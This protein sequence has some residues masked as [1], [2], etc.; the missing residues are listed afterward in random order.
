MKFRSIKTIEHILKEYGS[1]PGAPT[2]N[3]GG[4]V[5]RSAKS[6]T[7]NPPKSSPVTTGVKPTTPKQEFVP[8]KAGE[9]GQGEVYYNDRGDELGIVKTPIGDGPKP[10]AVVVQNPKNKKYSVVDA[11][12]ELNVANPEYAEESSSKINKLL[13]KKD[14]KNRLHKKIKKLIRKNKLIEQGSEQL[15]EINF[16]KKSIAKEALDMPINCGFEAE[17]SWEGISGGDDENWLDDYSWYDIEEMLDDQEGRSASREIEQAYEDWVSDQAMER[18]GDFVN[19][20]VN[21]R[22]EDEY[23][24]NE[25]IENEISE[26]DIEDYKERILDDLPEEDQ[27]EYEDWDFMNWGRQYVEEELMDDFIEY[28]EEE[29]RDSGEAMDRAYDDVRDDYD[30]DRWANYEYG[31]WN[32]CLSEYGH[33]LS[34]PDGGGGLGTV[35]DYME[36]WAN[37]NSKFDQ[38]K[39]GDYHSYYGSGQSYWRVESDSSIDSY[40]TGAEIISP[41]YSSPREMLTEMKKLFTWFENENVETNNSTGLHVTMSFAG[42]NQDGYG[43]NLTVNKVK[44]ALLLGDKYLLSTFGRKGN[45]YAKSQMVGLEKL[46]YKLKSDPNNI[47]TIKNIEHILMQGISPDKFSSINFKDQRD[48]NTKNQLI[49]FR[50]GG[51][52]D[53]HRDFSTIT[54]AVVRYATTLYAGHDDDAYQGDYVKA[55]FRL[56]NSV[57][58]ISADDEERVKGKIE[59]P[60]LNMLKDFFSKNNYVKY[61]HRLTSAFEDLKNYKEAS[62][63]SADKKWKQ[64]IADYEKDTGD[65]VEIEEV[66][67]GE[68]LRGYIRP[69]ATAPSRRAPYYLNKA[70]EAFVLSVAQAGY[71]LSQNLNRAPVNAKLIGTMRS[72]LKEFELNYSKFDKILRGVID[73]I[74]IS[75]E[76]HMEIKPKQRLQRVKN[77]VDRLFKKDIVKEPE[78]ISNAQVERVIQGMWH[79]VNS[80]EIKD[81]QQS[82]QFIKLGAQAMSGTNTESKEDRLAA[83]L[84]ELRTYGREYKEFHKHALAGSYNQ[85]AIFVPGTAVDKKALN[86]FID[87]LK[88]YPEWNH[89]VAKG[90]STA[91]TND[92]SYRENAMSKLLQKMRMRWEHIED[93]REE[94]PGL[95]ID[96]IREISDLVEY[97]LD[98]NKCDEDDKLEDI[99]PGE[100]IENTEF[101]DHYD[102]PD[103]MGMRRGIAT[104][105]NDILDAITRADPFGDPIAHRLRDQIQGYI[106]NSFERY[107]Y[108]KKKHGSDYYDKIPAVRGY[109]ETRLNVIQEFLE[110]F[111]KISQKLGFDSQQK[112]IDQKRKLDQKEKEFDK[113]HGPKYVGTINGFDFGGNIF[114]EKGFA[115]GLPHLAP[116]DVARALQQ[117]SNIHRTDYGD[118]LIMPNIHY[119]TALQASKM[120][121]NPDQYK[122]TWRWEKAQ[123]VLKKFESTYKIKFNDLSEKYI[124]IN[125]DNLSIRTKLKKQKVEFTKNLGDGREGVGKFGP[126][127]PRAELNGPY[128]EPFEPSSAASWKVNNPELAKKAEAEAEKFANSIDRQIPAQADVLDY[129]ESSSS[130]IWDYANWPKLTKYLKLD[131]GVDNQGV[132]LLKKVTDKYNDGSQGNID[133]YGMQRFIDSVK[134]AKQYIE[135]NYVSSGGNYF[136]KNAD[137][138][139][140]DDV[141]TVYANPDLG[142]I[143]RVELTD[144]SYAEARGNYEL[145]DG[146]MRNGIQLYMVQADVN[147]LVKFLT[148]DF[149]ENYKRAVLKAL[150]YNQESGGEPADLQQAL[151]LGRNNMESVFDKFDKL[152]LIEKLQLLDKVDAKKINEAWS[153]KYKDSINCSNPKGFSQKAHCAGKKKNEGDV[154]HSLDRRRAQKGKDKYHKA[155]EV[156]TSRKIAPGQEFDKFVVIPSESGQVGHIVGMKGGKA[157]DLGAAHITL[158]NALVDAYNRG[159]FTDLPLQKLDIDESVPNNDKI[160]KLTKLLKE[161]ILASDLKAQMEV[162]FVLPVPSMIRDFKNARA[163]NG[164]N[165]DLRDIVKGY[166]SMLHKDDQKRLKQSLKEN[167][168]ITVNEYDDLGSEKQNIIKTISGLDAS[169]E[170]HAQILDRIYKLLNSEHIDATMGTAFQAGVAD[171]LMPEK[172][173][174]K[175]IQDMTRIVGGID[176]DYGTM[177]KFL[178]R[179]ETTGTIVNLNELAQPINTFQNVFGDDTAINAFIALADYGVGKKQKGPGEYALACLS[180]QIRLAE[181]E[182]DLE[183]EGIGKVELKAALSS[184][185]G[186]IGYGGGSQKAKRAVLD[187]YA[188]SIPTV[189]QSIGGKGGSLGLPAFVKALNIDL[190]ITD[191]NNQKVRKAIATELLVMDLENFAG[192]VIDTIATSQDLTAIEDMYLAQNLRWYQDRDHFDALLLMHIPNRKTAM[193]R[194]PEDLIAF[195][196]SGHANSTSI[197]IIPTQAGAGREQWAQLTLNKGTL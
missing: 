61:M 134:A 159:G 173:K 42:K 114:A 90:H 147:G 69:E 149:S 56:I 152:S 98:M 113:K 194:T 82:R 58:K 181:G 60:A 187:K 68:T 122:D 151:A 9:I 72:T 127:I 164:D 26:D 16:N 196:R 157:E 63:P 135:Q 77:G 165:A 94:N 110:E 52:S 6:P 91:V 57:G 28:L 172:E 64:R 102:G 12:D 190:P 177:N 70:Q 49:E 45:S 27:E 39:W 46:A 11:D 191:V 161:P 24:L 138:S 129:S 137:G 101:K 80:K 76:R 116:K 132:N 103:F 85:S 38:V 89:P 36:T 62:D 22:K 111:D 2:Y 48:S 7:V 171:E 83:F 123:A 31:S 25:Y 193:I 185:G 183:V 88:T 175:V 136:R 125:D 115:Q 133:G 93:I 189:M 29:I 92:D 78:Y 41:V 81:S 79:A 179:L 178:K 131:L 65:K 156:P 37:E 144:T 40:G 55:L 188:D 128:S 126:L 142:E 160:H 130:T 119:Y 10:D 23:Y 120:L 146:M 32:S 5:N 163:Q 15:F 53:Y 21:E 192:P 106:S 174:A 139:V 59:H 195:R 33:Y 66:E 1:T 143:S 118:L 148:G 100:G 197:S 104:A 180:N 18:E 51:G 184:S 168:Y 105:L 108:N 75:A 84:D 150:A 124:D 47:K 19:E 162:Y 43:D 169:N 8:A 107:Y 140:G 121:A 182:G 20:I 86:K 34:N 73:D 186:R 141:A 14:K 44:L 109:V 30:I 54:K 167:R 13:N 166:M 153:K 71:D 170:K 145:F 67:Q 35:A 17:T 50:I 97:L 176:S 95:Y 158:A 155:V 99:M 96:T 74:E 4:T 154:S 3:K 112:A 87:H 117:T